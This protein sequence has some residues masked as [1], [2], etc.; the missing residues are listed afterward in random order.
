MQALQLHT[1][2]FPILPSHPIPMQM[3]MNIV[4]GAVIF[5]V[6]AVCA[7][8]C[9]VLALGFGPYGIV[10]GSVAAAMMAYFAPTVAGGLVATLQSIGAVGFS[11]TMLGLL[12]IIGTALSACCQ[13]FCQCF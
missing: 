10:A 4:V 13:C 11:G 8:S 9:I 1:L 5:V 2:D 12:G 6:V 3:L 7:I